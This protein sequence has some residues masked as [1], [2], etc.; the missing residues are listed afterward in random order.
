MPALGRSWGQ[1]LMELLTKG[2]AHEFPLWYDSLEPTY[3]LRIWFN[4]LTVRQISK[5]ASFL[6]EKNLKFQDG[7]LMT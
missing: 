6:L 4:I 5:L 3:S 7:S 2:L 1:F